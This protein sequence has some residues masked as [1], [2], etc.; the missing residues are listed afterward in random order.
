[1]KIPFLSFSETNS[2][3]KKEILDAFETFFDNQWYVLGDEVKK[4]EAI[5]S[6]F[7]EVKHTVGVGNGL[8]ALHIALKTLQ[9]G[10]GD[11]VIIPSNTFIATVL[12]ISYVGAT[13]VFVEPNLSTYNIDP[14][15]ITQAITPRTKAIIPVHLYGQACEMEEIMAIAKKYGLFVIEDNAQAQGAACNHKLTGSWGDINATSF[16]P[17][18]NLGALGDAGA[19]TT[20]NDDLAHQAMAL[21]NYGSTK[22][23]HNEII[24]FNTRLDECQAAILNVKL[25]YLSNWTS[26]RQQIATWYNQQLSNI[27]N[28]I[29]PQLA[30]TST[31][32][33]H[34][35][36]IRSNQ[37]D[38][39]QQY[40]N[41]QG[42]GTLIHYPV[43]PHLQE[44]YQDLGFKKGDFP[45]AEEIANT[46]LSLPLWPGM[47]EAQVNY[48]C[49]AIEL[50]Y[51]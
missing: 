31:H 29:L 11:E 47:T 4:F 19:I 25:G 43:P 12:A 21:R 8:D 50:F 44:A 3:I 1:M 15:L 26:Q 45:I 17:G 28:I 2:T 35:Y 34:L 51:N 41:T 42:I 37:R 9:I 18:K 13:P 23:Y 48:I 49:K 20:N 5:Y 10:I 40:L 30:G 22:K 33:Y 16:Y 24:G 46:C 38:A 27:K 36:V 32:V 39:L 14:L 6:Q 7:N